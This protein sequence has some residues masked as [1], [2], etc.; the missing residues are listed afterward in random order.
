MKKLTLV[1]LSILAMNH[2]AFTQ[3]KDVEYDY[4]HV[5]LQEKNHTFFFLVPTRTIEAEAGAKMG[6]LTLPV[7]VDS[8][9][10]MNSKAGKQYY[11]N[12]YLHANE[13]HEFG[14]SET[15][16][17]AN[18]SWFY[19]WV[20]KYTDNLKYIPGK[21]LIA[22]IP[23]LNSITSQ[24]NLLMILVVLMSFA[25][26]LSGLIIYLNS[27]EL[28][29]LLV[30][31]TN[32]TTIISIIGAILLVVCSVWDSS[33]LPAVIL[34][35]LYWKTILSL[36]FGGFI[37]AAF[38]SEIHERIGARLWYVL[39]GLVINLLCIAGVMCIAYSLTSTA[40]VLWS[41][42]LWIALPFLVMLTIGGLAA[43]YKKIKSPKN[44][45]PQAV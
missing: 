9:N 40:L 20:S 42:L 27:N 32:S 19:G 26:G 38:L 13:L 11:I 10:Y 43:F 22:Y 6:T 17:A 15:Y 36:G 44:Q 23:Q 35:A 16:A 1:I 45:T 39:S 28:E 29:Y 7:K 34:K 8:V 33:L 18:D 30:T 14:S 37:Y 3:I 25:I 2:S 12:A 4:T 21:H 5:R 41:V 24:T 31:V